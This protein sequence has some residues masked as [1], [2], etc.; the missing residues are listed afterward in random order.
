MAAEPPPRTP[1][2]PAPG[3]PP[4]TVT[5]GRAALPY[6]VSVGRLHASDVLPRLRF[7]AARAER[8]EGLAFAEAFGVGVSLHFK[9]GKLLLSLLIAAAALQLPI[10][11]Y[12]ARHGRFADARRARGARDEVRWQV[13]GALLARYSMAAVAAPA[14]LGETADARRRDLLLVSCFAA[15]ATALLGAGAAAARDFVRRDARALRSLSPAP[16]HYAVFLR[17]VS[18][19]ATPASVRRAVERAVEDARVEHVAV[20]RDVLH[21][22]VLDRPLDGAADRGRRGVVAHL[23]QEHGVVLRRR[24]QGP[25]RARVAPHEV[26]RRRRARAEERRRERGEARHEQQVAPPRV[27]GLPELRR[28]RDGRHGVAREERAAHLPAHLV[29]RAARAPRVRE[30]AV[31]RVVDE[32]GQLQRRR[33]DQQREQQLAEL[34]VERDAHAKGLGER[35]ALLALRARRV[36]PQPRQ[37]V[38][39][40]Q[41]AHADPVRQR[42]PAD[43]HRERRLAGR[44]RARR[45]RR[46]LGS[47]SR[48]LPAR[49]SHGE[50]SRRST[51]RAQKVANL[52][53]L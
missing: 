50:L 33:R 21:A 24:A 26:A 45:S 22:R 16:E 28:R 13:S 48:I 8:E 31:A 5:V 3:E 27:R 4:L 6:G 14:Q 47:H 42:R 15:L 23:A 49:A 51:S 18:D 35:E 43:R 36:E 7:N 34:E 39:G 46:R 11:V 9:L 10:L 41:P 20:H 37:H 17:E 44:R 38:G 40:V 25:Q 2:A 30:P 29:A 12:Y 19:D 32:D 53:G 1:R 52:V